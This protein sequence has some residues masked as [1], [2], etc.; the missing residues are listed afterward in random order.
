[1]D[2]WERYGVF[3]ASSAKNCPR[4]QH[5]SKET[6]LTQVVITELEHALTR[7]SS[8]IHRHTLFGKANAARMDLIYHLILHNSAEFND[9]LSLRLWN[10]LVGSS[11]ASCEDRMAGWRIIVKADANAALDNKVLERFSA[12]YFDILPPSRLCSGALDFAFGRLARYVTQANL[13]KGD[14]AEHILDL[15]ER[16]WRI[17]LGTADDDVASKAIKTLVDHVYL[18]HDVIALFPPLARRNVHADVANRCLDNMK[19]Y[20]QPSVLDKPQPPS[21]IIPADPPMEP[22]LHTKY[23]RSLKMLSFFLSQIKGYPEFMTADLRPLIQQS[24]KAISGDKITFLY[25]PL[26]ET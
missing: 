15:T 12:H 26:T 20:F 8:V 18:E 25:N 5:L 21:G 9:D 10:A 2:P 11:N 23:M 14:G 16:I 6:G 3:I 1:M 24:P 4:I 13:S 19:A 22:S 7:N 17:F